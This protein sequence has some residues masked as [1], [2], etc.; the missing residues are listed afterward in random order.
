LPKNID[1][2]I[3][4]DHVGRSWDGGDGAAPAYN[5]VDTRLAWRI[6]EFTEISV[7][8]Q[9]LLTR[10]HA[11]FHNAYEVR[12]TLVERRVFGKITWRF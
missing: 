2:D 4:V 5:R 12:H 11:E 9:S 1:W 8:G 10:L 3:S 6:G 7:V